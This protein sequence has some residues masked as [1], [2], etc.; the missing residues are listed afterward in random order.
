MGRADAVKCDGVE[1]NVLGFVTLREQAQAPGARVFLS[2]DRQVPLIEMPSA[3]AW[4][5]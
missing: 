2:A 5:R 3:S 1:P 4:D